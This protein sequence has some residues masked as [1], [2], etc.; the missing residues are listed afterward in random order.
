MSLL[1][2]GACVSI[3]ARGCMPAGEMPA[4]ASRPKRMTASSHPPLAAELE[5]RTGLRLM[6]LD[7][8]GTSAPDGRSTWV[9]LMRYNL[10]EL[11]KEIERL[12]P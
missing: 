6:L 4:A 12:R 3:V 11:E 9:K 7:V 5:R 1:L 10:E 2:A 8:V